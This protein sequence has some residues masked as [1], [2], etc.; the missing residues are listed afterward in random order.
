MRT[1]DI[2]YF[3]KQISSHIRVFFT[4]DAQ[5]LIK[6]RTIRFRP[7]DQAIGMQ[8]PVIC[9]PTDIPIPACPERPYK[10]DFNETTLTLW[11][12]IPRPETGTWNAL[13]DES[14]SLWYRNDSGALIPA[15]NLFGNLFQL[16]TFGEE[17]VH[18]KRDQHGRVA[19]AFSPR[20]EHDLLEVPA[21]NEAVAVLVAAGVGLRSTGEP[22]T[23]LTGMV[24]SPVVVLSHD[25]DVLRGNDLW[26]QVV[27][28]A[29]IFLPLGKL[30]PPKLDNAW[31][32]VRNAMTPKRFYFDNV[33]GMM[34][35]ERLFGYRSTHYLLNGN[36]GRFGARS[37]LAI[38]RDLLKI[39]PPQ[40]DVGIHYNYD[41]FLDDDRF[42]TQLA[43]L[44]GIIG[45][46]VRVGRA[47]YLRFDPQRSFPFL[48]KYGIEVDESS[49]YADRI[50]YRNGLAGCFQVY[51]AA[52]GTALDIWEVPLTFMDAVLAQQYGH[53]A[54]RIFTQHIYHL[55]RIGGALS[56]LFHPGQFFNPEHKHMLGVYHQLLMSCRDL[57]AIS[58]PARLLAKRCQN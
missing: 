35:L 8:E 50:G 26:T 10:V 47:H 40:W 51:D 23:G 3:A 34:D 2:E 49:G 1:S 5:G 33:T 13:P 12:R 48:K 31:W 37:G 19:A 42:D 17:V 7:Y 11:N 36:G 38:I 32:L 14:A 6:D 29:R 54:V 58:L 4:E 27:R 15:W 45:E 55:S 41:T 44:E 46:K 43:E 52:A 56:L 9:I 57:G 22:T 39:V 18:D 53:D 25:C 21:F 30:R 20:L 28:G 24:R 16:L